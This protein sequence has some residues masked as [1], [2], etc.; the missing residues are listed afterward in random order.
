MTLKSHLMFMTREAYCGDDM[1]LLS[2]VYTRRWEP[3]GDLV[4]DPDGYLKEEEA[5]LLA[6]G[7]HRSILDILHHVADSKILYMSQ[8]FGPPIDP[9]PEEGETL[10]DAL[11]R[12]AAGQ[13]M[14]ESCLENLDEA[15]LCRPVPTQCHGDSA[16]HLFRTLA[17]HD[18]NHGAQIEV[19]LSVLRHASAEPL[20]PARLVAPHAA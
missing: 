17:Q 12:L 6:P 18:I 14:V 13:R 9:L 16:A 15:E 20:L 1:S 11:T 5:H 8:A 4:P 19:L 10:Q 7:W 3:P 2:G